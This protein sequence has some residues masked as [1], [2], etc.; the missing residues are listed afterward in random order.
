MKETKDR[1]TFNKFAVM[2][3]DMDG[4]LYQLDGE[5]GTFKNSTLFKTVILNSVQFVQDRE[6]INKEAAEE[7][8]KEALKDSIGISNVLSKRYGIT[9]A[10]YFDIAWNIDPKIVIKDFEI[11]VATIQKLNLNGQRMFLL[12]AAPGVWME[13]VVRELG[14]GQ[15]FERKYHGE[16][17]GTKSEV[18]ES[19]AREFDPRRVLS[20]GD[21]LETDIK[22]AVD[23]GMIPFMVKG[24]NDLLNLI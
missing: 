7:I 14:I 13:N 8:I 16:M 12:T 17:F 24:P 9:R 6:A 18:F 22:P 1:N 20:V 21:Q 3:F 23:L 10:S 2:V 11:P 19:L 5:G 15:T 4:T